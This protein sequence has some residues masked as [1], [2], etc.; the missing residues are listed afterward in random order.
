MGLLSSI[1]K[2][3]KKI[4]SAVKKVVKPV[5]KVTRKA[6]ENKFVRG[7][8]M[9]TTFFTG[10][11]AIM[12]AFQAGGLKAAAGAALKHVANVGVKVV[13]APL[14]LI[15][16]GL[17]GAGSLISGA[18]ATGTGSWV[19][20]LGTSLTNRVDS[21]A[22]AATN[23]FG[24]GANAAQAA[25]QAAAAAPAS[26]VSAVG[27][28]IGGAAG[29]M[30]AQMVQEAQPSLLRKA[31]TWA[32]KNPELTKIG[33]DAVAGMTEADPY[34]E[35]TFMQDRER[36]WTKANE[37]NNVTPS[38]VSLSANPFTSGSGMT[39]LQQMRERNQQIAAPVG[40]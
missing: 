26:S 18:G 22:N 19:Q 9:A 27:S 31:L 39:M 20:S 33:V 12:G 10:A 24:T 14:E 16:A 37:T 40:V 36:M 32:E 35:T 21:V 34:T 7:L 30:G 25:T 1:K 4:G 28:N 17:K 5:I 3:T 15:S 13:R 8:L 29:Q 6:L 23:I 11:G 38:G 2:G